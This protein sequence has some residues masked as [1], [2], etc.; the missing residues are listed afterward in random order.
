MSTVHCWFRTPLFLWVQPHPP[1][2]PT[3]PPPTTGPSPICRAA[4]LS[5]PTPTP[6]PPRTLRR[7]AVPPPVVPDHP[8]APLGIDGHPMPEPCGTAVEEQDMRTWAVQEAL[9]E[10]L[11]RVSG[12]GAKRGGVGGRWYGK[13]QEACA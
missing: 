13:G 6:T 9:V 1:T 11:P 12:C 3:P 10:R 5:P 7:A 2:H 4:V 8:P